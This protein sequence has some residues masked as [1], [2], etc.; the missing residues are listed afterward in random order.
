M[1]ILGAAFKGLLGTGKFALGGGGR[2]MLLG[3]GIGGIYGNVTSD[4][5]SSTGQ[6]DDTMKGALLGLGAGA[7]TTKT[8][9]RGM[10]GV[11][12]L[13]WGIGKRAVPMAGRG[14]LGVINFAL[15]NPKTAMAMGVAGAGMYGLASSGYASSNASVGDMAAYAQQ[16][17]LPSSGFDIGMGGT[18]ATSRTAFENSTTGLVQGLHRGRH[19]G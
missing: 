13:G 10:K 17:G 6:F 3:A 12:K 19:R 18:R 4:N 5:A 9:W 11:G 1:A 14:G 7:A 15:R 16:T 2:R 8:F